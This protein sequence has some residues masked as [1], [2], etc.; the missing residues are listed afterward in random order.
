[1]VLY[2]SVGPARE[3]REI[4]TSDLPEMGMVT[5][6]DVLEAHLARLLELGY[7]FVTAGELAAL[8][9]GTVPPP[10]LAVLTFD[11]GWRD[12]LTRAAALLS[13]FG[14]RGTFYLCPGAFGNR[15]ERFGEAGAIL[16]Q[17]EARTLHE[18]GMELGSHTLSHHNVLELSDDELRRELV[19][20]RAL[21]EALTG[22]PCLTLAYP[23]GRHDSRIERA[24]AAAGYQ[25]AFA[26]KSGPW[27]R[28]AAPRWQAPV[29]DSREVVNRRFA[30]GRARQ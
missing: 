20:S 22:E 23:T 18:A 26:C 28:L 11:D 9:T 30:L 1:V 6:L 2:H 24:A 3:P 17:A 21:I 4:G 19:D 16:T 27:R 8:W 10:G 5:P 14:V 7:R 13:R 12:G 29:L 25:L 15:I